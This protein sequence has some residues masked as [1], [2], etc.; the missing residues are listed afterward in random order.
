MVNMLMYLIAKKTSFSCRIF[1][2]PCRVC[3]GFEQLS[4][5]NPSHTN[6]I[7]LCNHLSE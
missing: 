5:Q 2:N 6:E 1:H 4:E 3:R 7:R